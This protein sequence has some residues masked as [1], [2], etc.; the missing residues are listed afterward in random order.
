VDNIL[1]IPLCLLGQAGIRLSMAEMTIYVDPYL[2]NSVQTLH[3]A[4][5]IRQVQIPLLPA[6]VTDADLV[7]ITHEHTDH[8]DPHTLPMMA[9]ASPQARFI[10]PPPVA[11]K[12]IEWGIHP[13]RIYAASEEW[14]EA[15]SGLRVRSVPAAHSEIVRDF[16]GRL[17]CVGYLIEVLD[18]RIYIAGDTCVKQEMID[19]LVAEGPIHTAFL[20]VNE[21]NFFRKR[22]GITGN[23][24]VREAFQFAEEIGVKQVVPVHWDMFAANAVDPEEIRLIHDCMAPDFTLLLNPTYL[25][26]GD[27]QA[28]IIIRTLNE[29]IHLESLLER[30]VAQQTDGINHEIILVDSGSTDGTLEIATRHG[31]RILHIAREEFSFG[32][33]LNMG[34]QAAV[35]DILVMISGHCVPTDEYWLQKLCQ[36]LIDDKAE[37]AY[38]RQIG[39]PASHYSETRIFTKFYPSDSRIPQDGF[40]CNNANSALL[41]TSWERFRF[42]EDLTGLEDM[43]LAQRLVRLEGKIAYVANASAFHY[44]D[45]S[46]LQIRLRFEREAIALQKIMPQVQISLI[47]TLRY[48]VSSVWKDWRWARQERAPNVRITKLLRYRWNQY[49]GS[50]KGNHQHRQLSHI[51]K[52]RYLFPL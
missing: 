42:D 7:F 52:E 10:C 49:L 44:H 5:L 51:E 45:E 30:I 28:S 26:F 35:G 34:C 22:R 38:G 41:R 20:P 21:Q 25:S 3:A 8:C 17:E 12:L 23:M 39:G 1:N 48:I 36:P 11:L 15:S 2:S 4:D 16:L 47:D 27:V 6:D 40:F 46:W 31:C 43:E 9:L 18:R 29:A 19:V 24:S 14:F 50:W 37:Y 13:D 33:S 32:H